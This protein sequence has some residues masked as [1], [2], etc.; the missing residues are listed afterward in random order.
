MLEAVISLFNEHKLHTALLLYHEHRGKGLILRARTPER[1][2]KCILDWLLEDKADTGIPHFV[3]DNTSWLYP[4]D[5]KKINCAMLL[6]ENESLASAILDLGEQIQQIKQMLRDFCQ[7]YAPMNN[8]QSEVEARIDEFLTDARNV[9]TR[10]S[11]ETLQSAAASSSQRFLGMS[12]EG[13]IYSYTP[14]PHT[15]APP[16][17]AEPTHPSNPLP[18]HTAVP[19]PSTASIQPPPRLHYHPSVH[20]LRLPVW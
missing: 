13:P 6:R 7:N 14:L 4:V 2:I 20:P 8:P 17:L 10:D 19:L 9:S 1:H 18:L 16:M 3:A 5:P 15:P 12:V 11:A